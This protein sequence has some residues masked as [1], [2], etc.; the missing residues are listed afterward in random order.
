MQE[1]RKSQETEFSLATSYHLRP[2]RVLGGKIKTAYRIYISLKKEISD[3]TLI[4][5]YY[6][7]YCGFKINSFSLVCRCVEK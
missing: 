7:Y 3:E 2:F 4:T 6:H 1:G 5:Y